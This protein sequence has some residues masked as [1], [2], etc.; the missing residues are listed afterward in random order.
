MQAKPSPN[1]TEL[2]SWRCCECNSGERR[3]IQ[4]LMRTLK[5]RYN[6]ADCLQNTHKRHPIARPWGQAMGCLLWVQSFIHILPLWLWY[7]E[8]YC[9]KILW[10]NETQ[11]YCGEAR[12]KN[13][14]D[15]HGNIYAYLLHVMTPSQIQD[16]VLLVRHYCIH[17]F[18]GQVK[19]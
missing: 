18:C 4:R 17:T 10:Y 19:N 12:P 9:I 13:P 2:G 15:I 5:S 6:N 7:T 8:Q 3:W 14:G 11:E 16:G 1:K